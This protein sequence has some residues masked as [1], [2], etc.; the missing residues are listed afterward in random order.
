MNNWGKNN[1]KKISLSNIIGL[2]KIKYE[3]MLHVL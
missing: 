1:N 3:K 2:N